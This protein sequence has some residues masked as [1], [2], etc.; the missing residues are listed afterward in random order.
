MCDNIIVSV[1]PSRQETDTQ[2]IELALVLHTRVI[3]AGRRQILRFSSGLQLELRTLPEVSLVSTNPDNQCLISS[4][5]AAGIW[6]S[7]LTV[8]CNLQK[9]NPGIAPAGPKAS[10]TCNTTPASPSEN[11]DSSPGPYLNHR[12]QYFQT[13]QIIGNGSPPK[14][15]P[16][17]ARDQV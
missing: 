10:R 1:R 11:Q 6:Y 7:V 14:I 4:R 8:S 17:A 16:S 12:G 15:L 9:H 2:H 13:A 5:T 3:I